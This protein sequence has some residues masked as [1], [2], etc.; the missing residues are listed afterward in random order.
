[1]DGH[2]CLCVEA[3]LTGHSAHSASGR[4]SEF[5]VVMYAFHLLNL[6]FSPTLYIHTVFVPLACII[7]FLSNHMYGSLFD[8]LCVLEEE[9]SEGEREKYML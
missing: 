7:I 5:T 2:F 4:R 9:G 1:M 6:C 8:G 3:T